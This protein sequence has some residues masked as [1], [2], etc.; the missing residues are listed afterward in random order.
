MF[1]GRFCDILE[2]GKHYISLEQ[3]LS[4]IREVID[5]FQ[6]RLYVERMVANTYEYAMEQH[7]HRHRINKLLGTIYNSHN[8]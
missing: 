4:N 3:D 6:D 5:M 8:A 7:T 1:P 2:K